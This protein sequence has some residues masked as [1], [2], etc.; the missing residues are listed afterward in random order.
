MYSIPYNSVKAKIDNPKTHGGLYPNSLEWS[1]GGEVKQGLQ[2]LIACNKK[3]REYLISEIIGIRSGIRNI[4]DSTIQLWFAHYS[5]GKVGIPPNYTLFVDGPVNYRGS[6]Y[7]GDDVILGGPRK[8]PA[9]MTSIPA[10]SV[11]NPSSDSLYYNSSDGLFKFEVPGVYKMW[12][13]YSFDSLTS[14]LSVP[15]TVICSDTIEV[16]V[17]KPR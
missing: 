1:R 16:K 2:A 14:T 9:S 8:K 3:N 5:P 7:E 17:I 11:F 13:T 10:G 6:G 12:F 15:L 4:S